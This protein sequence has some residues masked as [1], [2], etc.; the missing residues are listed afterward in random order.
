MSPWSAVEKSW[1][2]FDRE[3]RRAT[4]LQLQRLILPEHGPM[5][6][7]FSDRTRFSFWNFVKNARPDLPQ[8]MQQYNYEIWLD[9]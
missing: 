6:N 2:Q 1:G 4:L 9:L 7:I 3:E 8:S 5:L